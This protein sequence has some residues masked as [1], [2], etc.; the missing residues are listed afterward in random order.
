MKILV[1]GGAGFIGSN[2]VDKY[3]DLGHRVSIVDNLSTGKMENV[4]S[5]ANFYH[6][7]L[8]DDELEKVFEKEKPS[9]VNHHAA[10]IDVRRSVDDPEFDARVNILGIIRLLELSKK[11]DVK[12]FIFASSGGVVYG[13]PAYLPVDLKHKL[14]PVSPYGASKL[15][16]EHYIGV[17]SALFGIESVIFRYANVY[18]PRQD[19][20]GEA[21]VV[22]IFANRLLSGQPLAIFGD[23][24]QVRDYVYVG[25]V[26]EANALALDSKASGVINIGTATGTSVNELSEVIRKVSGVDTGVEHRPARLGELEKIYLKNE[27]NILGWKPKMQFEKG[28]KITFDFIKN[29]QRISA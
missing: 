16:S 10:Q 14:K 7:D 6:V 20:H 17:Y 25:D 29:R 27:N 8:L 19:P 13:E 4:N 26:V 2:I 23:G 24:E 15:S 21:G 9:V 3:I 12:K 1:T 22:A 5:A 28:L 11:Y 18:G